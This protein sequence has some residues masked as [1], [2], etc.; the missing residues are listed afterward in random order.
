MLSH[1][2]HNPHV[3]LHSPLPLLARWR[4]MVEQSLPALFPRSARQ[5]FRRLGPLSWVVEVLHHPGEDRIFLLAPRVLLVV[6]QAAGKLGALY[7]SEARMY[8]AD[9]DVTGGILFSLSQSKCPVLSDS[10]IPWLL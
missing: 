9:D 6:P 4:Q 2:S 5:M 8:D 7:D 10:L 3:L 1:C